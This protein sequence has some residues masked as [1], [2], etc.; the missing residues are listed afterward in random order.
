M[1]EW[2]RL[3]AGTTMRGGLE[4]GFWYPVHLRQTDG[5]IWLLGPDESTVPMEPN[6]V[7]I[8][9]REPEVVT[10]IPETEFQTI[11]PGEPAVKLRYYGICSQG[12]FIKNVGE[13][14]TET[15]CKKCERTYRVENEDP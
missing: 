1:G 10:R 13:G 5:V 14:D 11:R 4:R 8:V 2:A 6:V 12:H 3:R 9:D 7:R 15:Q